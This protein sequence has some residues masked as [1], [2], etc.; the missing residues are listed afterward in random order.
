VLRRLTGCGRSEG[1]HPEK[2]IGQVVPAQ[3][4]G[5]GRRQKR[6]SAQAR[7]CLERLEGRLVMSTVDDTN[8]TGKH[9]ATGGNDISGPFST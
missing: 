3:R 4:H 9:A 7:P 8:I 2:S 6:Q 5:P 1:Y